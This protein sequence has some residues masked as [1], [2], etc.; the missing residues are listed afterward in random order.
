MVGNSGDRPTQGR[1]IRWLR[2][3]DPAQEMNYPA[4]RFTDTRLGKPGSLDSLMCAELIR[5]VIP[6]PYTF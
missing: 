3:M 2:V 6:E 4:C 1:L 5:A